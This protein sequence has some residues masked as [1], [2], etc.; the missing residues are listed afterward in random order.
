MRRG[1]EI[2]NKWTTWKLLH[3]N[4]NGH[5]WKL[6]LDFWSPQRTRFHK[7]SVFSQNDLAA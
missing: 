7:Q 5:E 1:S 2:K 4:P 6:F 3:F